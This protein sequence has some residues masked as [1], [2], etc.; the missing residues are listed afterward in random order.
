MAR[1]VARGLAA[2]LAADAATGAG[3]ILDHHDLA[4]RLSQRRRH[5]AGKDVGGSPRRERNDQ[6]NRSAPSLKFSC[7]AVRVRFG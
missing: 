7:S 1:A 2:Q 3:A 6:T 4:V 5:D